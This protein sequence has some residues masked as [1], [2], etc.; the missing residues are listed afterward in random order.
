MAKSRKKGYI[1]GSENCFGFNGQWADRA[2]WQQIADCA[3]GVA[4]IHGKSL[5]L[6]E[7]LIPPFPMSDYGTGCM[8]AIA[9]LTAI[10]KRAR[11]GGSYWCKSS[12]VQYDLLLLSKG[13]TQMIYGRNH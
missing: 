6:D 3:S 2:G 5:G 12:L 1:Y 13:Y 10:Y 4:W 11:Y 9:V 7:P 8:V